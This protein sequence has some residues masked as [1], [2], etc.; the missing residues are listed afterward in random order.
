MDN[1]IVCP[2]TGPLGGL[3][4]Q[5]DTFYTDKEEKRFVKSVKALIRHSTEYKEWKRFL[6]EDRGLVECLFTKEI[7]DECTI[8]FH[9]HPISMENIV[10]A[11]IDQYIYKEKPFS[12]FD[13]ATEI[14]ILHFGMKIGIV[15]MVKTLHEKFHNGFLKI[16]INY[17]IGE[18][19]WFMEKY[20][21]R[22]EALDVVNKYM[23]VN[24]TNH[25]D[26]D[27]TGDKDA[28]E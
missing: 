15:P 6:I 3:P 10:N 23:I 24:E 19:K 13:I 5:R 8:E 7:M 21:L 17:V 9:H 22:E 26:W 28:A 16:P 18:Y 27:Y 4:F 20:P 12:S 11:V 1:K 25:I 14:M 2:G